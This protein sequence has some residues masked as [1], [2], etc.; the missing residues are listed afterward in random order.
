MITW[1]PGLVSMRVAGKGPGLVRPLESSTLDLL[2]IV[3]LEQ[4][5]FR[6]TE[7]RGGTVVVLCARRTPTE[8]KDPHGRRSLFTADGKSDLRQAKPSQ[9]K[10]SQT[11]P[12]ECKS[13]QLTGLD[14]RLTALRDMHAL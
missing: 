3:I 4:G 8:A 7:Q 14:S 11:K 10:T 5:R 6:A 1:D 12:I 9:A 13:S 2:H